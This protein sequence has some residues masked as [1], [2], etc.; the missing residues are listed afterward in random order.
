[1][2][3]VLAE[4]KIVMWSPGRL[5]H[6]SYCSAIALC[7]VKHLRGKKRKKSNSLPAFSCSFIK[8]LPSTSNLLKLLLILKVMGNYHHLGCTLL[9][10]NNHKLCTRAFP[11][12]WCAM[13]ASDISAAAQ[14]AVGSACCNYQQGIVRN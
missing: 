14:A 5:G 2:L 13:Q 8:Q 6:I 7:S 12:Q 1:M 4:L 9:G 11:F 10:A 3:L